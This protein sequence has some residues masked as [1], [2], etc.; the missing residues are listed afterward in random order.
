M[1]RAVWVCLVIVLGSLIFFQVTVWMD[2]AD[3]QR[4]L[5]H[6]MDSIANPTLPPST[7]TLAL[8]AYLREKPPQSNPAY[9]LNRRFAFLRATAREVADGGGNCADRSRFVAVML[10]MR[11]IHAHK[12]ALYSPDQRPAHAVVEVE[13]EQGKMVADPLYGLVFPKPQGGFYGIDDLRDNPSIL[14]ARIEE[15]RAAHLRPGTEDVQRYPLNRYVYSYSRSVNW[16]K[17]AATHHLYRL[18]H[19]IFGARIDK[20]T[21]PEWSEQPAIMVLLM[22]SGIEAVLLLGSILFAFKWKGTKKPAF[23]QN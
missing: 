11:G 8:L 15:M 13:S 19:G 17:S 12:W 16:D 23:I 10:E 6:L 5:A 9:F 1:R 20:I 14:S 18:L 4:Y 7:Q 22:I 21:R 3:D 2:L